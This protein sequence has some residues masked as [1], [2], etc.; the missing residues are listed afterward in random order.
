[1]ARRCTT[2]FNGRFATTVAVAAVQQLS[3][4]PQPL[5]CIG[6]RSGH[7]EDLAARG[8]AAFEADC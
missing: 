7:F 8:L 3:V 4:L 6:G 2:R 1:M 5:F